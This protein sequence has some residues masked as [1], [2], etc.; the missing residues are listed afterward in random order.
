M[1][2]PPKKKMTEARDAALDKKRGIKEG[3]KKDVALDKKFGLPPDKKVGAGHMANAR[4]P[5]GAGNSKKGSSPSLQSRNSHG[6]GCGCA[7]CGAGRGVGLKVGAGADL[8]MRQRKKLPASS[9]ALPGKGEGAS[10][11]GAGS[12]PIP[13]RGHAQSA[14]SRVAQHGT[15]AEKATVRAKVKARFGMGNGR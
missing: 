10:G 12:Y 1:A 6:M 3:S 14:L 2:F 15:P 7:S 11:K 4:N 8:S 9:F 5:L 13:D